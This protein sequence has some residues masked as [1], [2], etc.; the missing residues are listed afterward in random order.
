MQRCLGNFLTAVALFLKVF[1]LMIKMLKQPYLKKKKQPLSISDFTFSGT[2]RFVS[3][4]TNDP[5]ISVFSCSLGHCSCL[6][7]YSPFLTPTEH[8]TQIFNRRSFSS[9][10]GLLQKYQC[11]TLSVDHVEIVRFWTDCYWGKSTFC[12]IS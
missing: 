9:S 3:I 11:N 7:L 12:Y 5:F 6:Q 2:P 8:S 10:L 1:L 4:Q